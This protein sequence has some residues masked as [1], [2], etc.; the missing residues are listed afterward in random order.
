LAGTPRSLLCRELTKKF[1]KFSAVPLIE[2]TSAYS[3]Q[4]PK[5][6]SLVLD[7]IARRLPSA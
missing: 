4:I 7:L 6:E 5:G 1:E 2:L 3:G